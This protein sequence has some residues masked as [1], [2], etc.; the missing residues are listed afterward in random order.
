MSIH[1]DPEK[2]LQHSILHTPIEV[3]LT[4]RIMQNL[5]KEQ[6]ITPFVAKQAK[7]TRRFRALTVL[8]SSAAG[9]LLLLG[10][11][12]ASPAI[13]SALNQ[14]P[15]VSHLFQVAGDLGLKIAYQ[16]GLY[17]EVS[18]SD[19]Q[20]GL[21][22]KAT[23][24]SYDGTRVSVALERSGNGGYTDWSTKIQNIDIMINGKSLQAYSVGN[25][26][27]GIFFFPGSNTNS[28]I[29][30]FGDLKNQGGAP[31]PDQ[32]NASLSLYI[33]DIQEPLKL[34]IPVHLNTGQNLVL[35]PAIQKSTASIQF[36]VDKLE[37][38]PITTTITTEFILPATPTNPKKN[39]GYELWDD[40]G[41]KIKLLYAHGWNTNELAWTTDTKFEP[42]QSIP[43]SVTIKPFTYLYKKN[44]N[45]FKVDTDGNIQVKYIPKLEI[46]IPVK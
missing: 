15:G 34:D 39:Y 36:K 40:R 6:S 22:V 11:S 37:I 44:S 35:S 33:K 7:K 41:K 1:F 38:T 24:V 28:T 5:E 23:T 31:F 17:R 13:A 3:D 18:T 10:S 29:V 46:T 9:L 2:Q 43:R 14:I 8:A 25:H 12:V 32:F 4:E 45:Q 42:V 19:T 16:D 30:E 20:K 26:T 21:T 27:A